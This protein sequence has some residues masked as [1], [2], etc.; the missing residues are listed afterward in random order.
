MSYRGTIDGAEFA[1]GKAEN[2]QVVLGEG[3]LL[4]DFEAQLA[5]MKAGDAKTFELRFPDDYHG[6]DVAGK[7]ATFE[8][9]VSRSRARR[10][11]PRS[12]PSSR[13]ASASPTAISTRCAPRSRRISSAR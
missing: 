6:K 1:G 13:K 8:V 2:Q 4:P 9:S 10:S 5:G 12:T 7:T 11:C 3:R